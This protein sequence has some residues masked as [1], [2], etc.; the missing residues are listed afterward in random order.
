MKV[1]LRKQIYLI[2]RNTAIG[3]FILLLLVLLPVIYD[4]I[5]GEERVESVVHDLDIRNQSP[6]D[7]ALTVMNW[8]QENFA[9]PYFRYSSDSYLNKIGVYQINGEYRFFPSWMQMTP[10]WAMREG[11]ANCGEYAMVFAELMNEAG[12]EAEVISAP[13][14]DH[15][16]AAYRVDGNWIAIDPSANRVRGNRE[17]FGARKHFARVV[18]KDPETG[19]KI[20]IT[21]RYVDVGSLEVNVTYNNRPVRGADI[22]V[23]SSYL[24]RNS[25]GMYDEPLTVENHQTD[26][27][28]GWRT[29]LGPGNYTLTGSV[30][31][32]LFSE[33]YSRE[34]KIS[35]DETSSVQIRIDESL[36]NRILITVE[37]LEPATF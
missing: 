29:N 27:T 23:E 34:V 19:E 10:S 17:E 13:G 30:G 26:A 15:A 1:D 24:A 12:F 28:G 4:G 9:S 7:A 32:N 16:W 3:L 36:Y 2:A 21:R 5:W 35:P 6:N 14:N 20:D 25:G 18:R 37:Q 33:T 22:L 8:E 11:L 31:G